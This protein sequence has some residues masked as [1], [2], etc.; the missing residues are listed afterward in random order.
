MSVT[1]IFWQFSGNG[2]GQKISPKEFPEN[3]EEVEA[4]TRSLAPLS[5]VEWPNSQR[6]ANLAFPSSHYN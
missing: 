5:G 6:I 4:R 2:D 3:I 1:A